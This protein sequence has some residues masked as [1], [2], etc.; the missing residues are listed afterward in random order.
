MVH[1]IPGLEERTWLINWMAAKV[2]RPWVP[3]CAP[4]LVTTT[5]GVGR[6]SLFDLM[7]A[8]IGKEYSY[9]VNPKALMGKRNSG[10]F[11]SWV[12]G[13]LLVVCEEVLAGGEEFTTSTGRRREVYDNLKLLID[14]RVRE[15]EVRAKHKDARTERIYASFMLATNHINALPIE[16]EDRRFAVLACNE[17]P[18]AGPLLKEMAAMRVE[19]DPSTLFKPSFVSA[20]WQYLHSYEAD[21]TM[22]RKVPPTDARATMIGENEG[23]GVAV[24]EGILQNLPGDFI[25]FAMLQRRFRKAVRAQG[26]SIDPPTDS[27]INTLW[28]EAINRLGKRLAGWRRVPGSAQQVAK[29]DGEGR[30]PV[31]V[32][33]REQSLD[34]WLKKGLGPK[35]RLELLKANLEEKEHH[36]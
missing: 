16:S 35:G 31:T 27:A 23:N 13:R 32:Y 26:D 29:L 24:L 7:S 34:R 25:T 5:H 9:A 36:F 30:K 21:F 20:V 3:F 12:A 17:R 22:A 14:D 19:D 1:L 33:A 11:N 10:D 2:Q 8:V 28:N 6:S 15:M 18:L 4:M